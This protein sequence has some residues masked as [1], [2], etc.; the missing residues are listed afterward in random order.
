VAARVRK[1]DD[2]SE[3]NS[4]AAEFPSSSI[5]FDEQVIVLA[6]DA[7]FYLFTC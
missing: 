3:M 7:L 6:G 4:I 5:S 1:L 2:A